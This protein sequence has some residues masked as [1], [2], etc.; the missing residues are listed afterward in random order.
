M[1]KKKDNIVKSTAKALGM[2][3]KELAEHIGVHEETLSRWARGTAEMP[4]MAKKLF[5]LLIIEKKYN[6]IKQLLI[7]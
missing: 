3:Q 1:N 7:D 6:T 5:E 4:D 2:T